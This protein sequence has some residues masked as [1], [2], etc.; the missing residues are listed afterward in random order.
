[1]AKRYYLSFE[2]APRSEELQEDPDEQ[3]E[4]LEHPAFIARFGRSDQVDGICDKGQADK[5]LVV[6]VLQALLRDE[7]GLLIRGVSFRATGPTR[8]Q[9]HADRLAIT[10]HPAAATGNFRLQESGCTCVLYCK[11]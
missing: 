11:A 9:F 1:V 10:T 4:R 3:I 5:D 7:Q 6:P 8:N 2:R